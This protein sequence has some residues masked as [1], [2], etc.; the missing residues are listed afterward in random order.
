MLLGLVSS[1]FDVE[2]NRTHLSEALN[3]FHL[4]A[5]PLFLV[6]PPH[7]APP[8]NKFVLFVYTL[9]LR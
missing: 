4:R 3:K 8:P 2:R 9:D 6:V 5:R 7:A 1:D